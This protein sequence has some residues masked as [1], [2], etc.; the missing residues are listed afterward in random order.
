LRHSLAMKFSR[1]ARFDDIFDRY[2]AAVA[3]RSTPVGPFSNLSDR[4]A[5]T[6]L[7]GLKRVAPLAEGR[8]RPDRGVDDRKT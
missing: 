8:A 7:P 3:S 4:E 6:F 2:E 5:V 1:F